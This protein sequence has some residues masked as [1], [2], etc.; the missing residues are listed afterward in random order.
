VKDAAD[1]V[2][3]QEPSDE[4][5]VFYATLD[6]GRAWIDSPTKSSDEI[7]QDHSSESRVQ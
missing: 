3:A 7:I 1:F 2:V 5:P 6:E 4:R